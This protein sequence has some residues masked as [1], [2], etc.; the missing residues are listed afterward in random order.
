MFNSV[1]YVRS[2]CE[3]RNIPISK[4]EKDCGFGNGYLN[5]KKVKRI[6]YDRAVIIGEYLGLS[7]EEI[8]TGGQKEKTATL[9]GDSLSSDD[10]LTAELKAEIDTMSPDHKELL[11]AQIRIMKERTAK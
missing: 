10:P 4:L 2:L 1:E 3:Q 6:S 11:L 5:P 7:P 8:L 9:S